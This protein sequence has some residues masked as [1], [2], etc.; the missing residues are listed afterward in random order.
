ME[1]IGFQQDPLNQGQDMQSDG[2]NLV[3]RSAVPYTLIFGT[4]PPVFLEKPTLG[5]RNDI[6]QTRFHNVVT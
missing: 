1:V 3:V 4:Q 5:T 6:L 2:T